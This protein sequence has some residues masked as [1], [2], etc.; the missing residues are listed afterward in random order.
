MDLKKSKQNKWFAL[1]AIVIVFL[2]VTVNSC[3][4]DDDELE[5]VANQDVTRFDAVVVT[6]WYDLIKILT[7][8]TVGYTPPVAAR[9]FGYTGVALYESM[10]YGMPD[11]TSLKGKITDFNPRLSN[12]DGQD[13]YWPLVANATLAEMTKYFYNNTTPAR[14]QAVLELEA[15]FNDEARA[16]ISATSF[17]QSLAL[18]KDVTD[19]IISYSLNDGGHNAQFRNFP[20][21]YNPPSGPEFWVPTP[22]NFA[23]ALQPYWGSNRPFLTANVESTQ[24]APP[25]PYS[26]DPASIFYER[27]LEVYNT[28]ENVTPE[29][30][31]IAQF[32]SDDPVTT[33]TPPGHSISILNQLIRENNTNL[34][35]SSIAFGKLGMGIA[36]AFISCWKTKY[37]TNYL[38]PI[39]YIRNNID[40]NWDTILETPPFPE[41]TSGHSVQSGALA[42]LMTDMFGDNYT[43]TD[44]THEDRT[45][46]DG[47]PRTY[48][49]FYEMANEAALSRLY[50]GIHYNEAIFLG[51]EQGYDIGRNINSLDL[52]N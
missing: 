22:P 45:D 4:N 29:Q 9:A 38:R 14:Y 25:P 43:F 36:D 37:D 27:A 13:I 28:V 2:A 21:D 49:T 16:L 48:S 34:A 18:S 10:Q 15:R 31:V 33:A 52:S 17:E 11:N 7:T 1:K 26:T 30:V 35:E 6:E 50:G 51:L 42:E 3:S 12:I 8:E 46:I 40:A 39:T 41:Y 19:Q 5:I 20:T 24:P 44:R 32:W 47:T 23:R